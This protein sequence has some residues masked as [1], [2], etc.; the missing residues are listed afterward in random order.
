MLRQNAKDRKLDFDLDIKYVW[1][2]FLKQNRKCALTGETLKFSTKCWSHDATASLDR[3][4]SLK[5]YVKGNVQWVHKEIN[6]MKQQYSMDMFLDWC[7]KIV[8]FNHLLLT[9]AE[10]I[11]QS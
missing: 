9:P 4:D 1:K 5:G 6:M 8:V 7:K 2:L 3:I 10:N 11:A